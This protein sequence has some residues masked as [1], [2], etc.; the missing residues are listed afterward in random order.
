MKVMADAEEKK[1]EFAKPNYLPSRQA[2]QG[3]AIQSTNLSFS[4]EIFLA[5]H[6]LTHSLSHSYAA[7]CS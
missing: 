1:S 4:S 3:K 6:S 7:A 5:A 2:R